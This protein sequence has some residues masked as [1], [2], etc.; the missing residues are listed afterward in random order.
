MADWFSEVLPKL[1]CGHD[2]VS[3]CITTGEAIC[4][5]CSAPVCKVRPVDVC[6]IREPEE[7]FAPLLTSTPIETSLHSVRADQPRT[8]PDL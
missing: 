6:E 2:T 8:T 4:A 7:P 3:L 5:T 1:P